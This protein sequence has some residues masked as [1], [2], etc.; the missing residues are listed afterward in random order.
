MRARAFLTGILTAA[1]SVL[2]LA[3]AVDAPNP[4]PAAAPPRFVRWTHPQGLFSAEVPAGWR[5]EG[6]VAPEGL[7]K[8]A[9]LIQAS[10]PDDR[11]MV[12][13]AHNWLFFMEYQ[14]GRYRPGSETVETLV[15]P[16]VPRNWPV[17]SELRVTYRGPN[18]QAVVTNPATGL[19]L[20]MDA[21]TLGLL[22]RTARGEVLAG[23]A[24]G[25][26]LYMP[27]PGT[28]GLW[29][30]RIFSGGIAPA[31]EG[32]QAEMREIQERL[33]ASLELAPGFVEAWSQA[34][35][36]TTERMRRYSA[37]MD[38]VFSRYLASTARSTS[39][40]KDPLE[41]WA[42]MMRGGHYE[43]DERTGEQHWVG[44]NHTSWWK[45]QQ[46]EIVGNDTGQAPVGPD[47]WHLLRGR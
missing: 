28:P 31:D 19:P 22:A 15:L 47:A 21:G 18:A 27:V 10:A 37:D 7:D 13:F 38:R 2:V 39:S 1:L 17:V 33:V 44:N 32:A 29:S 40:R 12:S 41:G 8:G 16:S 42:E 20:R 46:G 6:M 23:T 45:N 35:R 14:Y 11:A 34:H 3:A 5:V 9:F 4:G 24:M 43:D 30:L 36:Q 26:T 25:E